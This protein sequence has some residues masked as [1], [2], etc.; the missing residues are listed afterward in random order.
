MAAKIVNVRWAAAMK[1]WLH[2]ITIQEKK[3]LHLL[4]E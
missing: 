2:D 4:E 3:Q 1:I